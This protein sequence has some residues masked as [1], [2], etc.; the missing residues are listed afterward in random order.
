MKKAT[1]PGGLLDK[2][3]KTPEGEV[4]SVTPEEDIAIKETLWKHFPCDSSVLEMIGRG[5]YPLLGR[6]IKVE[7]KIGG[8]VQ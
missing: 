6:T 4:V 7:E 5:E 3:L 1:V 2:I 8:Q